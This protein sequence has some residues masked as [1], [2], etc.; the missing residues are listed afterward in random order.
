M[1]GCISR[2]SHIVQAEWQKVVVTLPGSL[3]QPR[4]SLQKAHA[5]LAT[6]EVQPSFR[7]RVHGLRQLIPLRATTLPAVRP[8][9]GRLPSTAV[10]NPFTQCSTARLP[11]ITVR[12]FVLSPGANAATPTEGN[13]KFV[14]TMSWLQVSFV[15]GRLGRTAQRGMHECVEHYSGCWT[16]GAADA[17]VQST[18]HQAVTNAT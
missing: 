6:H 15:S 9:L 13:P 12:V 14:G 3:G 5:V 8:V 17:W 7:H 11:Q 10:T 4:A 1:G 18:A 16:A 2:N